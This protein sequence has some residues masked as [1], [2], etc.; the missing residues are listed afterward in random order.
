MAELSNQEDPLQA[1]F[2]RIPRE[3]RDFAVDFRPSRADFLKFCTQFFAH[4]ANTGK[5]NPDIAKHWARALDVQNT[6][7]NFYKN[8]AR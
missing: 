4:P 5:Y 1:T 7:Q 6:R 2:R 8:R 3:V